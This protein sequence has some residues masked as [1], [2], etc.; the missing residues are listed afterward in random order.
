MAVKFFSETSI[1]NTKVSKVIPLSATIL[2]VGGGGG[3]GGLGGGGGGGGV[4][5]NQSATFYRGNPYSISI[6]A[7][8]TNVAGGVLNLNGGK[9]GSTSV[10]TVSETYVAL[11]GGGGLAY[12]G[13]GITSF[14]NGGSGGG[15]SVNY[16]GGTG[17]SPQGNN[18]GGAATGSDLTASGGGG[19][20][21][22]GVAGTVTS[23]G[24]GGQGYL[25][26]ADIQALAPFS[27]MSYVG[28]GGGGGC[29]GNLSGPAGT[30]GT[31]A[32]NGSK[33][34]VVPGNGVS[35]GSGGGGPAQNAASQGWQASG[36]GKSG[37]V[38]IKYPDSLAAAA[39]T[40]GSPNITVTGGFRYYTFTA[41][42]SI[43][44]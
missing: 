30:G 18:G 12:A 16:A 7:G 27:G 36:L 10:Q 31:G 5:A 13:P 28:S 11:G 41:D 44:F 6:G 21:A 29:R 32:G 14:T 8:G 33:G 35:F 42:G 4:I 37:V 23:G 24:N 3:A 20:S 26:P 25:L 40:S 39:S 17:T 19:Y 34:D 22:A 2:A 38:V 1:K 15:G 43:T 9:G